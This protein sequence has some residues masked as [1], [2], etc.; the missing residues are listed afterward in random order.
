MSELRAK[1]RQRREQAIIDAALQLITEKGYRNTTVEEIAELAEVGP[2][3]FYNYFGF[4]AGFLVSVVSSYTH[5]IMERGEKVLKHLHG[6]AE[7]AVFALIKAYLG[8]ALKE[9]NAKLLRE[10]LVAVFSEQPAV[11]KKFFELDYLLIGQVT[12]LLLYFKEH[13]QLNPEIEV[14]E[15]AQHLYAT[16]SSWLMVLIMDDERDADRFM[17]S[18]K[19]H[20]HIA[21]T[22]I[23]IKYGSENAKREQST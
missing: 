14:F 15:S 2:V 1:Q 5:V 23:G 9:Y 10:I 22:G 13:G 3:T 19:R 16:I 17:D 11:R 7:D 12:E 18:L 8:N 20:L 21:F 4:K 6:A